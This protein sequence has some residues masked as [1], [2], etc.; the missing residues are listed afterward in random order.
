MKIVIIYYN[1]KFLLINY[2]YYLLLIISYKDLY[3]YINDINIPIK[4]KFCFNISHVIKE[5]NMNNK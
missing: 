2:N 3:K 5:K 1:K 4:S